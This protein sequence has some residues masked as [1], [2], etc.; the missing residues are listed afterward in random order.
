MKRFFYILLAFIFTCALAN[1]ETIN[2]MNQ[3]YHLEKALKNSSNY[4]NA[5]ITPSQNIENWTDLVT[6]QYLPKEESE[7]DYINN[8]VS[9]ISKN[10]QFK[11]ISFHPQINTFSFGL[12]YEKG[13]E[14]YIEYNI[15]KC[16]TTK[17]NGVSVIQYSHKYKFTDKESFLT[18]TENCFKNDNNFTAAIVKTDIP[19]IVKKKK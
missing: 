7:F 6:V 11:L 18:A 5:Y 15:L 19:E 14:K 12:I 8:F 10:P 2:F 1:A 17:K 16:N 3:E 9:D 13:N 4:L